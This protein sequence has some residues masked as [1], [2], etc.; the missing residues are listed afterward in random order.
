[1]TFEPADWAIPAISL[2]AAVVWASN[3][4]RGLINIRRHE[5]SADKR[6][7]TLA[8]LTVVSLALVWSSLLYPDL[9]GVEASRLGVATARVALLIG[10]VVVWWLSRKEEA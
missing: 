2:A 4:R 5:L 1:M 6:I 10:G 7:A 9:I 3:L 8:T